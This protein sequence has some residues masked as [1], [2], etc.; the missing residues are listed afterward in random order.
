VTTLLRTAVDVAA[1]TTRH[2]ASA[3]VDA[4]LARTGATPADLVAMAHEV[5]TTPRRDLLALLAS[6]D[7]RSPDAAASIVRRAVLDAGIRLDGVAVP[8]TLRSGLSRIAPLIWTEALT[9]VVPSDDAVTAVAL[10]SMGWRVV[11]YRADEIPWCGPRVA[12]EVRA[13]IEEQ[14]RAVS[15][16]RAVPR[17]AA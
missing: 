9:A 2:E 16:R 13:L 11:T 12:H 5:S 14:R 15:A 7:G 1:M 10:R 17:L 3:V 6:A 8:I 4:V